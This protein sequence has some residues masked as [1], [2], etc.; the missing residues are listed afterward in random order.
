MRSAGAK[1]TSVGHTSIQSSV[2]PILRILKRV[3]G[4]QFAGI[5]IGIILVGVGA[6]AILTWALR[7]WRNATILLSLGAWCGLYGL[8]LL[9][10][11]P[12]VRSA[13]GGGATAWHY[14]L[15][16][17]T[18]AINV[19]G[20]LFFVAV[21]GTG[22]RGT[23]RWVVGI[24]AIYA[25]VA[26]ATDLILKTPGAAVG[27]NNAIVLGGI[28]V[29]LA[30]FVYRYKLG[31]RET[32]LTDPVVMTVGV[33]LVLFVANENLGRVVAHGLNLEP[34][35]VLLFVVCLGYA[36]ARSIIRNEAELFGVQRELQTAQRIQSS[37]LPRQV[38][39]LPGF[40]VAVRYIPAAAVAGDLYDII[41]LSPTSIGILV[42]DV[43]GH[44]IPAALVASMVKLAFDAQSDTA[45]DP[46]AVLRSM[47]AILCR[48]LEHGYVTA[49]YSVIDVATGTIA[50]ANAGHPPVMVW[51]NS[52]EVPLVIDNH[53]LMLGFMPNA[54]YTTASID[55]LNASDRILLYSDGVLEARDRHGEF[56]DRDRA[57]RWLSADAPEGADARATAALADLKQWIGTDRFEDDVTFVLVEGVAEGMPA[58][59]HH[60]HSRAATFG[61]Q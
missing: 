44:G 51:R 47:N 42:A 30:N 9:A 41:Q 40:E 35:G 5:C 59:S 16:F 11:Q 52:E 43:C 17:A 54:D 22:W 31:K 61:G 50:I 60:S 46:A 18:Y 10:F 1:I 20:M 19:P 34:L 27:P 28:S 4:V 2:V 6:L 36:V 3:S 37:L 23:L 13:L 26:I 49:V 15:Q 45:A 29:G 57:A 56:F 33:L 32:L 48:H 58:V 14:F 12:P 7:G 24:E 55:G 25:V 8:R 38:P 53:G 39:T 21:L